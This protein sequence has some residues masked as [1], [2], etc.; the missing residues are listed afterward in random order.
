MKNAEKEK[1]INNPL[2]NLDLNDL[3]QRTYEF[4]IFK[5]VS[6]G[7]IKSQQNYENQ[8]KELKLENLKTKKEVSSLKYEIELLKGNPIKNT[9]EN[10]YK[11]LDKEIKEITNEIEKKK[12]INNN[13]DQKRINT[14]ITNEENYNS[15]LL[16]ENKKT[17]EEKDAENNSN[18]S[19][20][21]MANVY[22]NE[23]VNDNK[24]NINRN[25]NNTNTQSEKV[26]SKNDLDSDKL[27]NEMKNIK[28]KLED[29]D[30]KFN[31]F[32]IRINQIITEINSDLN[33]KINVLNIT[34]KTLNEKNE[35]NEKLM[36]KTNSL[37]NTFLGKIDLINAKFG[38][39]ASNSDFEK[40]KLSIFNQLEI[41][42]REMRIDISSLKNTINTLK[43]EISDVINDTTVQDNIVLLKQRQEA[44]NIQIDK[45]QEFQRI[46]QEK[47]KRN[48]FAD[49]SRFIDIDKFND[50][51]NNQTKIIEKI[52][53]ENIDLLRDLTK[54]K[55][56]DLINKTTMKDLKNLEDNIIIKL[57]NLLEHIKERFV[58][59]KYL[60]KYLKIYEYNISQS[61]EEFKSE[62]KPGK[63]WI[64]AKKPL[65]H[66]C[67]SCEAYLGELTKYN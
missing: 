4:D 43:N 29:M 1:E 60:E 45:L 42:N 55:E 53:R 47:A 44:M 11:N 58:Q 35:E 67:A 33:Q 41:E 59:K 34:T 38:D 14:E 49:S 3:F 48:L 12:E 24:N 46:S 62:L 15:V 36:N 65:G 37:N 54:V 8:L 13:K 6:R 21:K 17:I 63:N 18:E 39:Y 10:I 25:I 61:L 2:N 57:E 23:L 40:Y 66:L 19:M 50:Y 5:Y 30:K 22:I 9:K 56:V 52:K 51:K 31:Q 20:I 26:S 28:G 27:S 16:E 7:L 64:L 32:K